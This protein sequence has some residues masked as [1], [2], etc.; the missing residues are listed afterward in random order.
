MKFPT[1]R[2]DDTDCDVAEVVDKEGCLLTHV[3]THV[4]SQRVDYTVHVEGNERLIRA[5]KADDQVVLAI[6]PP[7]CWYRTYPALPACCRIVVGG[8]YPPWGE[9]MIKRAKTLGTAPVPCSMASIGTRGTSSTLECRFLC[10]ILRPRSHDRL[11]RRS[12][13]HRHYPFT[14]PDSTPFT[15]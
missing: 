9:M 15:K 4:L 12:P 2:R 1:L 11:E 5:G 7:L 3:L 6:T 14:A 13:R 10:G 8:A